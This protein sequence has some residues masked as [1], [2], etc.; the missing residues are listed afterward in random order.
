MLPLDLFQL[1]SMAGGGVSVSKRVARACSRV[2]AERMEKEGERRAREDDGSEETTGTTWSASTT[3]GAGKA[4]SLVEGDSEAST[5]VLSQPV[6]DKTATQL[7]PAGLGLADERAILNA[8]PAVLPALSLPLFGSQSSPDS[9]VSIRGQPDNF[10]II[11]PGVY[12]SSYPQARDY[13]FMRDLRLRTI[14]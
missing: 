2:D 5:A 13:M 12:R 14:V 7:S 8:P 11:A 9:A 4:R 1:S 3:T 6:P 10:G